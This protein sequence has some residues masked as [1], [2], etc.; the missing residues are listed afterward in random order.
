LTILSSPKNVTHDSLLLLLPASTERIR[1]NVP[2]GQVVLADVVALEVQVGLVA[3][4]DLRVLISGPTSTPQTQ[5]G[6]ST[7]MRL[8]STVPVIVA[9][10]FPL[11]S[12]SCVSKGPLN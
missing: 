11:R 6:G 7:R 9:V 1:R 8:P 10:T 5:P 4:N 2:G 3:P 12:R